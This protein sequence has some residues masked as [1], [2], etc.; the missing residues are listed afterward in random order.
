M[1]RG[2]VR[3]SQFADLLGWLAEYLGPGLAYLFNVL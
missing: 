3:S 1:V 2:E